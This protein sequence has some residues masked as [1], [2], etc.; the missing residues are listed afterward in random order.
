MHAAQHHGLSALPMKTLDEFK[1]AGG[2][3]TGGKH[4]FS[5]G[6]PGLPPRPY[7]DKFSTTFEK[8]EEKFTPSHHTSGHNTGI[9]GT[10]GS[11][12]IGSRDN[13][14]QTRIRHWRYRQS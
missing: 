8:L 2:A 9:G 12:G 11:T 5:R 13:T 6:I 10:T 4:S 1:T 7:N 3:L 14:R